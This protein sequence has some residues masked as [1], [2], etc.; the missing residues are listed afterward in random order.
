MTGHKTD[1][2]SV[3]CNAQVSLVAALQADVHIE[4]PALVHVHHSS[5]ISGSKMV[6]TGR[7]TMSQ[8][9]TYVSGARRKATTWHL[10]SRNATSPLELVR[11]AAILGNSFA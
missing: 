11:T 8:D 7:L 9:A 1:P 6:A 4:V 10:N 3:W 5:P 2:S